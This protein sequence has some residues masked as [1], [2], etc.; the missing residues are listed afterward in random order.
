[1]RSRDVKSSQSF[2]RP[3]A[4]DVGS[5]ESRILSDIYFLLLTKAFGVTCPLPKTGRDNVLNDAAHIAFLRRIIVRSGVIAGRRH[6]PAAFTRPQGLQKTRRIIDVPG[7]NKHLLNRRKSLTVVVVID[8]HASNID[9]PHALFSGAFEPADGVCAVLCKD[10][11]ACKVHGVWVERSLVSRFRHC[12]RVEYAKR[13]AIPGGRCR[14]LA[15]AQIGASG[16][17]SCA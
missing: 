5:S 7:R 1:M 3:G 16:N 6:R 2:E 4:N 14:H 13:D 12:D 17:R 8:L 11:S 10:R 9:E 15:F